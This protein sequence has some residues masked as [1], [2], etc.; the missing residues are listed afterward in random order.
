[1]ETVGNSQKSG[2]RRGCGYDGRPS[3]GAAVRELLAEAVEP[4]LRQPALE[5]GAGVDAGG[6][7]ALD[8]DL[9]AAARVVLAAEEVVEADFVERRR[10]RV[11]RDVPADADPRP[12]R[13]V[14]RDRGVPADEAAVGSLGVLVAGEP[15][16]TVGRDGVDVVGAGQ[17]GDADVALAGALE[18]ARSIR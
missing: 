5:V 8:E 12:L 18:H 11:G 13:A 16:L 2:I 3:P 7:V 6:G 10:R 9:V 14:H 17:R 4:V 1:M 15:R